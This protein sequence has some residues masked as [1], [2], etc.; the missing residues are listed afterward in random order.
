LLIRLLAFLA[1]LWTGKQVV[2]QVA[3]V[4]NP[5]K[6]DQESPKDREIDDDMVKDPVCQ[7]YIPQSIAIQKTV[8]HATVYFCSE[9]CA[10][11]FTEKQ[12]SDNF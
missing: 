9:E 12:E 8:N 6:T 3:S 1:L 11:K 4:L 2:N 10:S 5:H 7:T